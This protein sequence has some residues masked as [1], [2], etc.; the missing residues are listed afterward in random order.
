MIPVPAL[1]KK[2]SPAVN[3][4]PV[5]VDFTL[6]GESLRHLAEIAVAVLKASAFAWGEARPLAELA[7]DCDDVLAALVEFRGP[8]AAGKIGLTLPR[9]AAA[10]IVADILSLDADEVADPQIEDAVKELANMICGQWLTAVFGV[11]PVF[12]LG[13]PE[14]CWGDERLW[15][16][17][18]VR[19][20]VGI[21]VEDAPIAVNLFPA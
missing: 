11:E 7:P 13:T 19:T 3:P 12:R 21:D 8:P 17:R 20:G 4:S 14:A 5:R 16:E 9:S 15:S 10:A 18:L 1:T 2:P 6:D